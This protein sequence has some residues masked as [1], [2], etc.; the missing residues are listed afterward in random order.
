[1]TVKIN[2]LTMVRK[3]HPNKSGYVVLAYFD[4]TVNGIGLDGCALM[5]RKGMLSISP[6]LIIDD[7]ERRRISIADPDLRDEILG[8]ILLAYRGL[9]G[10]MLEADS[11][12]VESVP[13]VAGDELD[14]QGLSR[15]IDGAGQRSTSGGTVTV[16]G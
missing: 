8:S 14:G 4:C 3:P 1:M 11:V 2:G 9:G 7:T 6:P 13:V 16:L 12:P 5:H 10:T 15:F